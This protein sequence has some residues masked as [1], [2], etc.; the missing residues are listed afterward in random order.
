MHEHSVSAFE[1]I[2]HAQPSCA[3]MVMG[4]LAGSGK[5]GFCQTLR[6]GL[7]TMGFS[8]TPLTTSPAKIQLSPYPRSEKVNALSRIEFRPFHLSRQSHL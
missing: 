6:D 3:W 7:K 5:Y 8:S 2:G 1:D 4:L